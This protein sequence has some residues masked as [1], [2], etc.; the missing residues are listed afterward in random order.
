[1]DET[2]LDELVSKLAS[3]SQEE[4]AFFEKR[5]ALGLG[6]GLDDSGKLVAQKTPVF[7]DFE[8]SSLSQVS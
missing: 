3:P 2:E 4:L 8:A 7:I 1:M 5:R 6:V